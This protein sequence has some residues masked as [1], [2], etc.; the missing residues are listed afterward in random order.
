MNLSLAQVVQATGAQL[1]SGEA[2]GSARSTLS[3]RV[4]GGWSIDSRSLNPSDLYIAIKGE[5]FDGHAF[6]PAAFAAGAQ[7]AIVSE[8]PDL[9]RGPALRVP[10]TVEALQNLA[11]HARQVWAKPLVAVTGSAGKTSTKEIISELLNVRYRVGK[12]VGN[13][14]NHIGLPLTLLRLPDDADIGVVEMGM[15]H[16]GEI[17][18]L[19]SIALPQVGVVTNVGYAHIEAF[20]SIEGVAAAKRELIEALAPDGIAVLNADDQRVIEFRH[21]H[22]GK[23]VT[24]GISKKADV[25]AR[26]VAIGVDGSTFSVDGVRFATQLTGRHAISNILAGLAVA[27]LFDIPLRE[28]VNV[29]AGMR[30]GKMRGERHERRGVKVLDDSYNSNPEAARSMIDVLAGEPAHRRIAVL[31]EMLELGAWA[32]TLH[33]DLGRYAAERGIDVLVGVGGA[34]RSMVDGWVQAGSDAGEAFFFEAPENAGEFL[35]RFVQPGD[36]VLFKG[37]RG[38]HVERALARM[39]E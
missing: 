20:P 34:S 25:V 31:G 28:L 30:P 11:R 1:I 27:G 24:Y 17:R 22:S 6:L 9:A 23:V 14:N 12:T 36:A 33:R 29:V 19:A 15:N 10:D 16:A 39:E 13:L 32:E 21:F 5:R 4:I 38:T 7:A 8:A 35:H 3:S 2:E 37:S 18:A 26:E